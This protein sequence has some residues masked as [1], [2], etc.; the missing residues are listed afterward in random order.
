MRNTHFRF[1]GG[2]W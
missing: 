1:F 2:M